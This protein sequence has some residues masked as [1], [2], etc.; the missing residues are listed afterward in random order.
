MFLISSN[1]YY[2]VQTKITTMNKS[3]FFLKVKS[4][5]LQKW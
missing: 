3:D 4:A 2:Y 5:K 1:H